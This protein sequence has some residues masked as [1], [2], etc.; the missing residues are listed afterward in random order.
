MQFLGTWLN[1]GLGSA[2][3][4]AGYNDLKGLYQPKQFYDNII[5]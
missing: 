5:I 2:G 3:L 4:T 1:S